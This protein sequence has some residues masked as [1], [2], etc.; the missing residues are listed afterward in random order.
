MAN[1]RKWGTLRSDRVRSALYYARK[2]RLSKIN[3]GGGG[4]VT[5]IVVAEEIVALT[6]GAT[7]KDITTINGIP[8]SDFYQIYIHISKFTHTSNGQLSLRLRRASDDTVMTTGYQNELFQG[9]GQQ[10][11]DVSGTQFRLG[12]STNTSYFSLVLTGVGL[13]MPTTLEEDA[14][15]GTTSVVGMYAPAEIINGLRVLM[16]GAGVFNGGALHM[17]GLKLPQNQLKVTQ[18]DYNVLSAANSFDH[19][20]D[21]DT[22]QAL[23]VGD[24]I[25]VSATGQFTYLQLGDG[26]IDT[27]SNYSR[28]YYANGLSHQISHTATAVR[29]R[30]NQLSQDR[31]SLFIQLMNLNSF[32]P[33]TIK[34][35][36]IGGVNVAVGGHDLRVGAGVYNKGAIAEVNI[37]RI[38]IE[39]GVITHNE[40]VF[41][42][43]EIK[44]PNEI[45]SV[46]LNSGAQAVTIADG[47]TDV[48]LLHI[49]TS[50]LSLS[51]SGR[52]GVQFTEGGLALSGALDYTNAPLAT[53]TEVGFTDDSSINTPQSALW[54][55]IF[56]SI[57]GLTK[58]ANPQAQTIFMRDSAAT[59]WD[60]G[61]N[62]GFVTQKTTHGTA[63]P[64]SVPK[65]FDG[66]KLLDKAAVA[67]FN[68]GTMHVVKYP[69]KAA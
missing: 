13:E 11:W 27:G 29:I 47:L 51:A 2:N 65:V 53:N 44:A 26:S 38:G 54:P 32:A 46:S 23:V 57:F 36:E 63:T 8:I 64:V 19:T 21:V 7:E 56:A 66:V 6:G 12:G 55:V 39:G 59:G 45:T 52:P 16:N 4:G 48:S 69:S 42:V 22:T 9:G 60:G 58:S 43:L 30:N 33:V 62:N 67:N 14:I 40:G 61:V 50:D 5:S 41:Y 25:G 28:L 37:M 24:Q 31:N 17:V 15:D 34:S 49:V 68:G 20:F 35:R 3:G 18:Y 1:F 10:D